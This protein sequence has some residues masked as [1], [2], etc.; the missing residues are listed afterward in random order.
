M[1]GNKKLDVPELAAIGVGVA[2][3]PPDRI[4]NLS[5]VATEQALEIIKGT[6]DDDDDRLKIRACLTPDQRRAW[7]NKIVGLYG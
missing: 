7:R 4:E 5:P 1:T 6:A 3:L 2:D